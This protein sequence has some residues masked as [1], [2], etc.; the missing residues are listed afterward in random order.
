MK[1]Q[2]II[3]RILI[4]LVLIVLIGLISSNLYAVY[5]NFYCIDQLP[6]CVNVD[7]CWGEEVERIN[8][9]IECYDH[10]HH[11]VDWGYCG[12]GPV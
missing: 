4:L 8:C 6:A 1:K 2:K 7:S 5:Q 9:Y 12:G 10:N 3:L 11:F